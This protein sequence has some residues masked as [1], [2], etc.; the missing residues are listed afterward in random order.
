[1]YKIIVLCLL[2]ASPISLKTHL[3]VAK[4]LTSSQ[5]IVLFL[6]SSLFYLFNFFYN[7]LSPV[8]AAQIFASMGVWDHPLEPA[9]YVEDLPIKKISILPTLAAIHCQQLLSTWCWLV[10]LSLL[11]HA[12]MLIGLMF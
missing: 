6:F 12:G 10:I 7:A 3:P 9:Q 8:S 1:M 5:C 4:P 2:N 11:L